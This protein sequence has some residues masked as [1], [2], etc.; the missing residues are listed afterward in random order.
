MSDEVGKAGLVEGYCLPQD[1]TEAF[2]RKKYLFDQFWDKGRCMSRYTR[3]SLIEVE[4]K[5]NGAYQAH[6]ANSART[7]R[8]F[9]KKQ[10]SPGPSSELLQ[11]RR[12]KSSLS[13]TEVDGTF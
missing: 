8:I 4:R 1:A 10:R 3:R 13:A 5:A 11:L 6:H 2:S 12:T 9:D 7:H